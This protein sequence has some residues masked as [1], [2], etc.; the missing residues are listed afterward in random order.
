MGIVAGRAGIFHEGVVSGLRCLGSLCLRVAGKAEVPFLRRQELRVF[1]G[2]GKMTGEAT[3][4]HGDGGVG[5]RHLLPF[6]L[7]ASYAEPVPL[8]G[9]E[10]RVLRSVGVVA[11]KTR[12]FLKGLV[13]H[14]SRFQPLLIMA[15]IAESAPLFRGSKRLR[16]R[17]R[18]VAVAAA[19]FGNGFMGTRLQKFRLRRS[20]GVVAEGAR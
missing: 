16:R 10:G 2:M 12:P 15:L 20:M 5:F 6:P 3:L 9:K 19:C 7:V 14:P 8:P 1:C 11:G 18:V 4:P 17:G 13:L